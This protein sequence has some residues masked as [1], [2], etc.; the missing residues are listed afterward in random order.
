MSGK[1]TVNVVF[2]G[3]FA[4]IIGKKKIEVQLDSGIS[5]AGL[6]KIVS[7]YVEPKHRAFFTDAFV[8]RGGMKTNLSA[9]VRDGDRLVFMMPVASGG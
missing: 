6:V 7:G 2:L 9:D 4:R 5:V 8:T 1:I 3:F